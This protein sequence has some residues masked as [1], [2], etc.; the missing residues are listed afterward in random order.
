MVNKNIAVTKLAYPPQ[1]TPKKKPNVEKFFKRP[2][3]KLFQNIYLNKIHKN[4]IVSHIFFIF[5]S[6]L[7]TEQRHGN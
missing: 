3:L 6:R 7:K 4:T 1:H 5:G 2:I